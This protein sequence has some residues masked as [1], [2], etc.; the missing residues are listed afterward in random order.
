MTVQTIMVQ[1]LKL[2]FTNP[3][4]TIKLVVR[5]IDTGVSEI[6]IFLLSNKTRC[7]LT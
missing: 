3:A 4:H 6:A 2:F 5:F 7:K 1:I